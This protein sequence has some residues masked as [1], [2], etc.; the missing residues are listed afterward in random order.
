M[1]LRLAGEEC[2]VVHG[3]DSKGY[4]R[5]TEANDSDPGLKVRQDGSG[6]LVELWDGS[7]KVLYM[8]DGR[9]LFLL[10]GRPLA[11]G[12]TFVTGAGANLVLAN[13]QAISWVNGAGTALEF[14][15]YLDSNNRFVLNPAA[16][17]DIRGPLINTGAANGGALAVNDVL[18]ILSN[19]MEL[20]EMA[21]P[22]APGA[23]KARLFAR[24]NGSGK[25][26]LAVRFPTGAVQ[27]LATEP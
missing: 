1:T 25:T 15:L 16:G 27:V 9:P 18:A 11:I 21:D 22:A 12:T 13:S 4:V 7:T 8:N 6:P 23:D 19:F 5:E 20:D 3:L 17:V 24:D 14:P 2:S 26:Q 10:D